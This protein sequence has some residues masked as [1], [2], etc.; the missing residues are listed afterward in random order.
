MTNDGFYKS[1]RFNFL[2]VNIV[3]YCANECHNQRSGEK[4][5]ARMI[6]A[7]NQALLSRDCGEELN[8]SLILKLARTI[9]NRNDRGYRQTEVTFQEV[10]VP[11]TKAQLVP[12]AMERLLENMD[13]ATVDEFVRT[14][15]VIHPFVDGNGRCAAI[16]HNYLNGTLDAPQPLPIYFGEKV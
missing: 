2:Q 15:L 12:Q 6:E 13:G 10:I 1:T 9:D 4:S 3:N 16:L 5:V 8:E 14:F 11:P 7:Y